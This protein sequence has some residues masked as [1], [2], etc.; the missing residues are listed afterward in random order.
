MSKLDPRLRTYPP[1]APVN[2][3][4]RGGRLEPGRGY[5]CR[6]ATVRPALSR[7]RASL[8][9]NRGTV[10]VVAAIAGGAAI[11]GVGVGA[12]LV[13]TANLRSGADT[14]LRSSALLEQVIEVEGSVVD[15]ETGLRGYVIT[16]ARTFL[17][18]L[19]S[20]ERALPAQTAALARASAQDG[21]SYTTAAD[22]LDSSAQGYMTSYVP[23]VLALMRT[24]TARA[25]SYA[26]TLAGKRRLD[27]IRAEADRLEHA[28]ALQE[29]SRQRAVSSTASDDITYG[30]IILVVLV[31]LTLISQGVFGR[32]FLSRQRALRRS[33]AT[34][35]ALQTS[36]LPLAIPQLPGCDLAIRFTPAGAGEVV[37]GD[38]YDVFELDAPNRFAVIVGDVCG[39]GAV[40]AATTAVARWT[41]RSAS[42][43]TATPTEALRHLNEVMLRRRQQS[44]FATITYLTLEIATDHVHV[45]VAC[46]GHPPPIVLASEQPPAPVPARGD[47]VG[48]WPQVRLQTSEIDLARGDLI[49]AYSDGATD[50]AAGPIQPLEQFLLDADTSTAES[51]AAAI[52][53]RA[54][55]GRPTPRDDIAVVAVQFHGTATND[56]VPTGLRSGLSTSPQGGRTGP[57]SEPR[58]GRHDARDAERRIRRPERGSQ[59]ADAAGQGPAE[60]RGRR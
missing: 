21:R 55:S 5:G 50:F 47:L 42:L 28:V 32:L 53:G 37:S 14:A 40:A 30:I 38:F 16:D 48:I 36:L 27:T 29:G 25:R 19:R 15:A 24:D 11:V 33:R 4:G 34:A 10:A 56:A 26:V 9:L 51:V 20:A 13:G 22:R 60:D 52:E 46:A 23:S 8:R 59:R 6:V 58:G 45:T 54:L 1:A 7:L 2:G 39:K 44:L 17:S 49:V 41:L 12:L 3:S 31:L 43:L 35:S 57:P 18:P